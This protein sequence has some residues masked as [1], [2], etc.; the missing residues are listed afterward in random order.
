VSLLTEKSIARV[1]TDCRVSH[2]LLRFRPRSDINQ[3]DAQSCPT[4]PIGRPL[5]RPDGYP[6]TDHA[7]CWYLHE[8]PPAELAEQAVTAVAGGTGLDR[9]I[10]WREGKCRLTW[11][12]SMW[13]N[14]SSA[15]TY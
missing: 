14:S 12:R 8:H 6:L 5:G 11:R 10:P 15:F 13:A 3:F 1:A 2:V 9:S 7:S 4:L